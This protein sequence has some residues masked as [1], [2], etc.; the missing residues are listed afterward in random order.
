MSNL[1]TI[2]NNILAD[3]GIDDINVVVSTGSYTNPSW[4]VSLPWTKITGTPTTLAGYGI[5]DAYTQTQVNTLLS[6]Y[7]PVGRTITING[8]TFDLSA[9]RTFNVGT[10]TSVTASSPLFSS[11]GATPNITIQQ[12]S[13]S[14]NGFLSS[15]DWTTF[16]NKQ[17][18]LTNPVTGTGTTNYLPKFTGPSTIGD[19]SISDV[20]SSPLSIVKNASSITSNLIFISPTT[21]TNASIL[22]LDNAGAGSFYIGRQNSAGNSVLLS[23]LGAYA[24]VIGHTGS[25]TLHLVTNAIS[26]VQIDGSGATTFSSSV[27]ASSIIRSGGTSSQYLMADG[28]VST[29]TNPVT[30]TGSLNKVA[31]WGTSTGIVDS[32]ITDAAGT[33]T[34]IDKDGVS[35]TAALLAIAPSTSTNASILNLDNGGGGTFY[36]GRQNSAGNSVLLSG[37]GAY[38]SVI[39]HTASQTLHLVTGALSRLAVFGDGNIGI[40][41]TTDAGFKLDVNGTGRFTKSSGAGNIISFS[42]ATYGLDIAATATGGSLQTYNTNQTLDLKT[43]GT[44]SIILSTA[45]T[46]RLTIASTGSATFSST[47]ETVARFS[48]SGDS[49]IIIG[50][51]AAQGI[52]SGEQYI[53]YQN[54]TTNSNAWMVGMDDGEDWRFAYGA[55]GEITDANS[56]IRLTQGGNVLIGTTT[57]AGQRLQVNG[58]ATFSVNTNASL[59]ITNSGQTPILSFRSNGVTAA[60]RIRVDEAF[61]GGEMVFSTKTTGGVDTD[62]MMINTSGN[63]LIGIT[64]DSGQRLQVSGISRFTHTSGYGINNRYTSENLEL[65][66]GTVIGGRIGIQAKVISSGGAYPLYLSPEGGGIDVTGAATFSSSVTAGGD[67]IAFASSDRRLK[68]NLTRIE[69]SLEKVGKLSGYSFDWNSNQETYSGKDYGVVAQEVEAIFPELVKTRDNGYKAVKYEKL[70]PV[71]IEAIKE[72]NEKVEK[73]K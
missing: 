32:F 40:N 8:T 72:L 42:D 65:N 21:G 18:A 62:R 16:N 34:R 46:P 35:V 25:Q 12:A 57:D 61:G 9:N 47:V 56:L 41:T 43:F 48:S 60:G 19:S 52:S 71:L 53:T 50:G 66:F 63:V 29:L 23:G 70:I 5:T 11:G 38:A 59:L 26:R 17:N 64:T 10:V 45:S 1:A 24:S 28:S 2:T 13:G 27:T 73:L 55:V 49:T 67:V 39:G 30:G 22:N 4:I 33:A 20:A 3:S 14:Q 7:V 58:T 6:G 15:T 68:D 51:N 69:S 31:K 37:L 54:G 44:G 36:V